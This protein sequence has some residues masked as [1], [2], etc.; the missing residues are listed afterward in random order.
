MQSP[1]T[2]YRLL[3]CISGMALSIAL[4]MGIAPAHAKKTNPPCAAHTGNAPV[5]FPS[6]VFDN[7]AAGDFQQAAAVRVSDD[8]IL[9][10][11]TSPRQ[12]E[13]FAFINPYTLERRIITMT[14]MQQLL[15]SMHRFRAVSPNKRYV[16]FATSAAKYGTSERY[17]IVDLKTEKFFDLNQLIANKNHIYEKADIWRNKSDDD[18]HAISSHFFYSMYEVGFNANNGVVLTNSDHVQVSF[19]PL[20]EIL[21]KRQQN[22]AY[23]PEVVRLL[24]K[25]QVKKPS[26]N[27]DKP[28]TWAFKKVRVTEKKQGYKTYALQVIDKKTQ[29]PLAILASKEEIY[30]ELIFFDKKNKRTLLFNRWYYRKILI[31]DYYP[32]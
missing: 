25:D 5:L 12:P 20:D 28:R 7:I 24:A 26:R 19:A 11:L 27:D 17:V 32:K 18:Y 21:K 31:W 2:V 9:S 6:Q 4:S 14:K 13:Q 29:K 1:C 23:N 3:S 22:I 30:P 16:L 15:G 8:E 10:V